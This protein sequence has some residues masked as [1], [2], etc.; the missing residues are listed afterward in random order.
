MD[1]SVLKRESVRTG[2]PSVAKDD[3]IRYV[4]NMLVELGCV[5]ASYVDA[6]VE[7]DGNVSTFLGNGVAMPHG[8]FESKEAVKKTGIVVAQYPE[9]VDWGVGTAHIVIGLGAVG[10]DHVEI[11][12]HMAEILQDEEQ[13]EKLWDTTDTDFLYSVLTTSVDDDDDDDDDDS[14]AAAGGPVVSTVTISG[15]GGLHARPASIIV[16]Y[17]KTFGG[18]IVIA[19][20]DKTAKANSIM[21]VLALGAVANDEVVI[22]VDGDDAAAN[23]A[24]AAEIERILT[25]PENEL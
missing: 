15:E 16:E 1:S 18:Q 14:D 7:R 23:A 3:A 19:K 20:G 9:G 11:L 22:T 13:A 21:S 6:M 25:T 24:A 10:D 5:D 8:T 17:A 2:L 4:G 12:S